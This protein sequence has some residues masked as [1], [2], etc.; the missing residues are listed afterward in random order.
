MTSP[1]SRGRR[2]ASGARADHPGHHRARPGHR[3]RDL[4]RA[5]DPPGPDLDRRRRLLRGG[6]CT[7]WSG[8]CSDDCSAESAGRWPRSWCS[9]VVF[10]AAG[11]AARRLRRAVGHRRNPAGRATTRTVVKY[12]RA[13]RGPIGD[14]LRAHQRPAVRAGQPGDASA[15]SPVPSAPPERSTYLRSV[16]TGLVRAVTIFVLSFLAVLEG[17]KLFIGLPGPV[18]P[19]AAERIRRV[20]RDCAKTVTG[21]ISGN[22][23]ISVICGVL[24]YAVL[25]DLRG[26]LPRAHRAVRRAS[27]T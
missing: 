11:R 19:A 27:W 16:G 25:Q 21:Y 13:G 15:R 9:C 17:P 1:L 24:T 6:A 12:H 14:L 4:H 5:A 22:L 18:P 3:A 10:V 23:L 7:R 2:P 20:T 8:G 26:A